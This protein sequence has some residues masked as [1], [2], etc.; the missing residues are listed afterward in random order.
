MDKY[1]I[2]A[3]LLIIFGLISWGLRKWVQSVEDSVKALQ[4]NQGEL[5][6]EVKH[7]KETYAPKADLKD[8]KDEIIDRLARIENFLLA[9]KKNV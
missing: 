8:I 2:E 3:G 4:K 9:S 5:D 1:I 7:I 6:N